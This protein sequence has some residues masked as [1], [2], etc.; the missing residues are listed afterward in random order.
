MPELRQILTI[1]VAVLTTDGRQGRLKQ[2]STKFMEHG[3]GLVG[4]A[5]LAG[6]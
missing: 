2:C 1:G 5:L 3:I 4:S 6:A